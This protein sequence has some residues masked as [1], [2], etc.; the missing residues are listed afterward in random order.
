[1]KAPVEQQLLDALNELDNDIKA[2][3]AVN[4]KPSL[5][6]RFARIDE[7]ANQLPR[8]TDPVLLHYLRQKS[9]EKARLFLRGR[10]EENLRGRCH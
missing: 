10:D 5:L 9:Y 3:A 1:M 7:L 2:M 4:P 8:D 6:P